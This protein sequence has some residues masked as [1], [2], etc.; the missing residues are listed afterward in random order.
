MDTSGEGAL[1]ITGNGFFDK[2]KTTRSRNAFVN[3]MIEINTPVL[4][5]KP[6]MSELEVD[7]LLLIIG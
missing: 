3:N 7:K 6:F 1:T 2:N 5:M 4:R